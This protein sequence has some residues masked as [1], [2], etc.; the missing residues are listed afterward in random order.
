MR[1]HFDVA[2]NANPRGARVKRADASGGRSNVDVIKKD[3]DD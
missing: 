2:T 3:G 1:S